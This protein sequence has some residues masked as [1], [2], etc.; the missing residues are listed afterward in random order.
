MQRLLNK[1]F[2]GLMGLVF[3]FSSIPSQIV[4]AGPGCAE[5]LAKHVARLGYQRV[6]VVTDRVLVDLGLAAGFRA[7]L[8]AAGCEVQIHDGILPDPT[9]LAVE[10]CLDTLRAQDSDA[11][12]ALGG[13]SVIDAAK[14][15]AASATNGPV[16]QLAGFGKV[17]NNPIPLF[18]VPTTAGTGSEATIVAV[19]S[20]AETHKKQFILG[21]NL[22]P[23]AVALDPA[24]QLSMPASVTAATG[25]D[26]LTHAIEAYLSRLANDDIRRSAAAAVQTIFHYLPAACSVG[27]DID[28]REAMALAAY[29]AGAAL[30]QGSVGTVHAIAH[31]LGARYGT[32][33]G[34][35]NAVVL[36]P[37]LDCYLP[38]QAVPLAL[39][40]AKIGVCEASDSESERAL[41]FIAAVRD[42]LRDVGLASALPDLN[43]SDINALA[44][45]AEAECRQYPVPYF[46]SRDELESVLE[47]LIDA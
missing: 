3:R 16:S 31:Q 25:A 46:L 40:A 7:S 44:V 17:K 45:D 37:V 10:A 38:S 14:A 29:Q 8:E 27:D 11:I 15:M 18:A 39:L 1:V 4:F 6:L 36:P 43:Q 12:V 26:A 47:T 42:L 9:D 20:D 33:H 5:Q 22:L 21:A 34:V 24:L 41:K 28:A 19:I 32:P 35:A 30:N 2:T 13:G 23:G